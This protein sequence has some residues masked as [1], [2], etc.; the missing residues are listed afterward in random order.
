MMLKLFFPYV[1]VKEED[2]GQGIL[3]PSLTD[4]VGIRCHLL[5]LEV[6][7]GAQ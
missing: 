3:L 5:D 1:L 2:L 7:T 4:N 6:S